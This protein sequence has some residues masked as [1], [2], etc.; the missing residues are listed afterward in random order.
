MKAFYEKI[1]TFV[2]WQFACEVDLQGAWLM[3]T[4]EIVIGRGD[5]KL[6]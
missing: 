4:T 5:E 1:K 3:M 6:S 2:C